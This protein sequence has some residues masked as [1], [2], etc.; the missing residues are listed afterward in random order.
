MADDPAYTLRIENF[1]EI[2]LSQTV[3]EINAFLRFKQ[4][5]K[6]ATKNDGENDFFGKNWH[7]TEQTLCV[8]TFVEIALCRTISDINAFRVLC[9]NSIWPP[10]WQENNF[11]QKVADDQV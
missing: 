9:R 5:F 6:M 7:M 2:T 3:S 10:K 4:K 8:K 1:A 11:W